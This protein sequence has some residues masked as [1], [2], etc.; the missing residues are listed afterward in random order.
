MSQTD[1]LAG[2]DTLYCIRAALCEDRQALRDGLYSG[3]IDAI[4]S[5]HAPQDID[6]GL[7]PF[8]VSEP[9]LSAYDWFVHLMLRMPEVTGLS[10]SQ[11]VGKL[12]DAPAR[13]LGLSATDTFAIGN[14]ASFIVLDTQATV[15]RQSGNT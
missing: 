12:L 9:G 14:P 6:A 8:P 13:I 11:V 10:L 5:D 15:S 1:Q 7:A 2:S 4:C 3:V